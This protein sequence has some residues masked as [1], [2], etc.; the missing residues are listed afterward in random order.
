MITIKWSLR[1]LLIAYIKMLRLLMVMRL[2]ANTYLSRILLKVYR[3]LLKSLQIMSIC[4]KLVTKQGLKNNY[5]SSEDISPKLTL[6]WKRP[7]ILTWSC[8][9][10]N[11]FNY[12][13]SQWEILILILMLIMIMASYQLNLKMILNKHQ[14]ILLQWWEML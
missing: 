1:K 12:K 9:Q 13:I 8:T 10:K 5:L 3:L 6:S 2:S 4:W 7:S 11:K 14:W